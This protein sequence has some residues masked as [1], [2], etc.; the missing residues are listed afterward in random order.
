MESKKLKL[1]ILGESNKQ[2]MYG[3]FEGF[4]L[5]MPFVWVGVI[6]SPLF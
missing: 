2:Q 1:P 5:M 6:Y 4:P 3:K